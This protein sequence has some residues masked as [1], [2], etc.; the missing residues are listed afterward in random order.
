M[1]DT[2]PKDEHPSVPEPLQNA[3][4]VSSRYVTPAS[5]APQKVE[6]QAHPIAGS[7]RLEYIPGR[8][9]LI[10]APEVAA[11][12]G[13]RHERRAMHARVHKFL[14]FLHTPLSCESRRFQGPAICWCRAH[15]TSHTL[16]HPQTPSH[17]HTHTPSHTRTH[18]HTHTR[19]HARTRTR[20][21]TRTRTRTR[22]RTHRR[23]GGGL[24]T[25]GAAVRCWA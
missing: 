12:L 9:M 4:P 22:T 2:K 1:A 10:T 6:W 20:T 3:P 24:L 23:G 8:D 21:G 17:T 15:T 5:C 11:G 19:A 14:P 7:A 13:A 16:T 18:T 25:S